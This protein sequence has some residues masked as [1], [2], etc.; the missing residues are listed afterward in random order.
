VARPAPTILAK[1]LLAYVTPA[2]VVF[3]LFGWFAYDL[4]RRDLEAEL[5]ARLSSVAALTATRVR[6]QYLLDMDPAELPAPSAYTY[7]RKELLSALAASGALRMTVFTRAHTSLCDT[8]EGIPIG[9]R[10]NELELDRHELERVFAGTPTSSL[11]FQGHDGRYYKA[12]YAPVLGAA[13]EV[14]AAL[15]VEAPAAY[16]DELAALARRLVSYGVALAGAVVVASIVVATLLTRPLRRLA[17][18]AARIGR[19]ELE[20]PIAAEGRDEI[21]LLART[22]DD[23]RAALRARDERLRMMLAGIA[24]EV[25]NPLGGI[26]LYAGILRDELE[27]DAEKRGHVARIERELAHLKAVVG[28]FLEFARRPPLELAEVDVG[29]LAA[30]VGELAGADAAAAEIRL[31][32]DAAAAPPVTA[33]AR[34][35]RRALLNLLRNAIQATP[36]AGTVTLAAAAAGERV[37]I[38]VRD[39]GAGIPADRLERI[40]VPF[41]TTKEKGTGLGLAFVKEIIDEHGGM[42]SVESDVGRGTTFTIELPAWA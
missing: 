4:M 13:G 35:L 18:A 1:L 30:E 34:Q 25:R 39:T 14:V 31:V 16:F 28:D 9:H 15:R 7:T 11:L 27:G 29:A 20:T 40:F 23:M 36:P 37:R 26:E 5:G 21:A 24:H 38:S 12:G 19:G 32:V 3:A 41:Y 6:G 42:L 2:I 17:G 22:L 10:Y 8:R 33:D